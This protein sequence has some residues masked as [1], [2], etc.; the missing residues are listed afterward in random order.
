MK[1]GIAVTRQTN[2]CC[3]KIRSRTASS[4]QTPRGFSGAQA[5]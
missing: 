1:V 3:D 5:D 4:H 2:R